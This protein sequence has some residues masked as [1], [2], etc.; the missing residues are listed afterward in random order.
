MNR[1]G[2]D[3]YNDLEQSAWVQGQSLPPLEELAERYHSTPV[4]V[5]RAIGDLIYEGWL[6]RDPARRE[7]LRR[8]KVPL[9]GTI[10]GNHSLTKEAQRRGEEPGTQILTFETVPA[11]P[12]VADRLQLEPGDQVIIMERLRTANGVPVS[13]EF[14]YY[15]AKLYP[16]MTLEMFTGGGEGQSSF[17]IMQ[18]KFN[19]V[20]DRAVDEVTV[21][22]A[23]L[24][25]AELL[26]IDP[27]IPVLIRFRLTLS[28]S[29]KAIKGSRA[30]YLFKAGYTLPI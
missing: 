19:L 9:W 3:L 28:S 25:E 22:A 20:P 7:V 29:G 15:P 30:I 8:V 26:G 16:G 14:S 11:W 27:G 4:E 12:I 21:A 5:E 1:V 13:L 10:T 24:R 6:E 18:E 23:E 2:Q 17:K